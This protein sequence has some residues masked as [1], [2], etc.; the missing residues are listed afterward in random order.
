MP[1]FAVNRNVPA[2]LFDDAINRRQAQARPFSFLLGGEKWFENAG[3]HFTWLAAFL[4]MDSP[5]SNVLTRELLGW[6]PT[7]PGLIEDLD[8]GHYFD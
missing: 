5:A 4:A 3:E 2:A 6:E 7:H 1:H 8:Q